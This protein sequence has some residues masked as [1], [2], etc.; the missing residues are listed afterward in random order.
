M[1]GNVKDDSDKYIYSPYFTNKISKM[2]VVYSISIF[3]Q[4]QSRSDFSRFNSL[5][6]LGRKLEEGNKGIVVNGVTN[7]RVVTELKINVL[8]QFQIHED[9]S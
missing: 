2:V 6:E 5:S 9:G 8:P 1:N 7:A 3:F 4:K